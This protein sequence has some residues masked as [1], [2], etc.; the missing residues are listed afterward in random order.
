[1]GQGFYSS[2]LAKALGKVHHVK[3][4]WDE[5]GG[6]RLLQEFPAF[7]KNA[8]F[9]YCLVP[10]YRFPDPRKLLKPFWLY[11]QIRKHQS[12]LVHVQNNHQNF[13]TYLAL[14]WAR[15]KNIPLVATVH[16]VNLHPGDT[17]NFRTALIF[18][19]IIDLA[20]QIIVHG[21]SLAH[22]LS[23]LYGV[24]EKRINVVPH[25]NHDIYL[26]VSEEVTRHRPEPGHVLFFG[27]MKRY[28]GLEY[29]MKAAPLIASKIKNLK[30]VVAGEG[31]DLD[32]LAPHLR[33]IP[34]FEIHN[35]F[36]THP[37]A[38]LLFA[39]ASVVVVPYIEGS[40]S[41]PVHMAFSFGRPVVATTVGAIPEIVE[42]GREG[43]L[44]SPRDKNG[45]AEAIIRI[46]ANPE[47]AEKMGKYARQKA[48]GPLNWD[49]QIREKTE[50]VYRK[51]IEA[52][53]NRPAGHGVTIRQRLQQIET[54]RRLS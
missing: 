32:R 47:M 46:L 40:Q 30:I 17:V 5:P 35:R 33:D 3:D 42:N 23:R 1:M 51:A 13:E 34:Y 52:R 7:F 49:G 37:E 2:Q 41:G 36:L 4:A 25:G 6:S 39:R 10:I 53:R 27:R 22:E 43:F 48:D 9:E 19:R 44:V 28:K 12:D 31:E 11:R 20:D 45:L 16:D 38:A 14:W 21:D 29:L 50:L 54:Y 8:P 24:S 18:F 26:S 15:Q